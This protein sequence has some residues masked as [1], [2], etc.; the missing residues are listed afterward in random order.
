MRRD[1]FVLEDLVYIISRTNMTDE[2][3]VLSL[4]SLE[5]SRES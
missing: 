1:H 3:L 4:D 2:G 5:G